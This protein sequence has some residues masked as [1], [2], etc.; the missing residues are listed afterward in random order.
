MTIGIAAFGP[1]SA[2]GILAGL[3]A[4]ER[5]SH[6]AIGGF[7]SFAA[8]YAEGTVLRATTQTDGVDAVFPGEL[9]DELA[10]A[11]L[12]GLIS[13]GPDRPEP[14]EDFIAAEAGVGIVTG[15]RMPHLRAENGT[16]LNALV[17]EEMKSGTDP[18]T[19]VDR[20]IAQHADMDAGF[21]ACSVDGQI[22]FGSTPLVL[23]R[24]DQGG[25]ALASSDGTVRVASIH[26]AVHPHRV[27]SLLANEITLDRMLRPEKP[28][29][30]VRFS[31]GPRL[32]YGPKAEVHVDASGDLQELRHPQEKLQTGLWSAGLGDRVGVFFTGQHIGWL[33]YEPFMIFSEGRVQS[34]DGKDEMR[35]PVYDLVP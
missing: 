20:V 11:T 15:H 7:V 13:S 29:A 30:W 10:G 17:L 6:G 19:A 16:A 26:N 14:L 18:Q 24:S 33:G 28:V 1:K 32:L 22:G 2:I 12:A 21:I 8:I 35:V 9:P 31:S 4:V 25:G 34:I 3:R 23:A 27:T 5:V